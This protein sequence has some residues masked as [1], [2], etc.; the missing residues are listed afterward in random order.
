MKLQERLSKIEKIKFLCTDSPEVAQSEEHVG[1]VEEDISDLQRRIAELEKLSQTEDNLH[2]L[3]VG[4]IVKQ[5]LLAFRFH[6]KFHDTTQC[7]L[8]RLHA[9][10]L[11]S[12][13][14]FPHAVSSS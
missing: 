9:N 2:F 11:L 1:K 5:F 6:L 8:L 10:S 12:P 13:Q 7:T 3:Q 4:L 14:R